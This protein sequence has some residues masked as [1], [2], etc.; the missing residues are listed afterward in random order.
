MRPNFEYQFDEYSNLDAYVELLTSISESTPDPT[1]AREQLKIHVWDRIMDL[2]EQ[3]VS[4]GSKMLD[5]MLLQ[6]R[7][8]VQTS[9]NVYYVP[10]VPT[11]EQ[12]F[13]PQ[14]PGRPACYLG[15]I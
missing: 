4:T 14:D 3:G 1:S 9:E 11:P 15:P 5:R 13:L 10:Y 12:H 8:A 7:D 6:G 2:V